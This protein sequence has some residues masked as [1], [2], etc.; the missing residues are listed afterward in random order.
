MATIFVSI[1]AVIITQRKIKLRGVEEAHREK[2]VEIYQKFLGIT[3]SLI[4]PA[5][6]YTTF[7][8][9]E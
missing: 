6:R 8:P 7:L 9:R 3:T 1:I 5:I 2:K 4:L